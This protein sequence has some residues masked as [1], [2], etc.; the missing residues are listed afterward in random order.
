MR[1]ISAEHSESK[2][3]K[4]TFSTGKSQQLYNNLHLELCVC[5]CVCVCVWGVRS[6]INLFYRD[7]TSPSYTLYKVLLMFNALQL[8]ALE[9]PTLRR[10]PSEGR[11]PR[12]LGSK[13]FTCSAGN[14]GSAP[15]LGRSPGRGNG[16]LLQCS[17]LA[18]STDR[19]AWQATVLGVANMAE[20]VST[21]APQEGRF[22]FPTARLTDSGPPGAM[23]LRCSPKGIKPA[24]TSAPRTLLSCR[25]HYSRHI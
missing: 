17:C 18:N 9:K 10:A 4:Q 8:N 24:V 22:H 13:E 14:V 12:R 15:G 19:G 11:L 1:I 23:H 25:C 7:I 16:N 20:G 21:R 2:W 6:E 3:G 5:V